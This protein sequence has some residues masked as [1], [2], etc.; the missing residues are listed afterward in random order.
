M[1]YDP[2]LPPRAVEALERRRLLATVPDGF[3]D[4]IFASGF[5]AAT[6][7]AF[8]P[9][10]RIFVTQ[11]TGAV[12]VVKNGAQLGPPFLSV[13]T[14]SNGERGLLG[15]AFDPQFVTN[16][17]VYIYYTVPGTP[18][19]NRVSRFTAVANP[20]GTPGD[21]AVPG[22]EQRIL[23][24]DNLP[25]TATNHNGGAIHFGPDGKLYVAVGDGAN[26]ANSQTLNNRHG[27]VLRLNKDG[28]IPTDNPF[29]NTAIG[30]NRA[31]WA[32]G[33]RNPF[34]FS[35]QSG[36]SRM[37]INDV[38][39]S[40]FEEINDG[41]RG[42]N[43]GWP[44]TEGFFNPSQFPNFTNPIHAYPRGS[45]EGQ[46]FA[47]TGGAFYNPSVTQFPASFAGDYFFSD[48]GTGWIRTLD[49]AAGNTTAH[50]AGSISQPVDLDVG[51]D[52]ALYYLERGAGRIGRIG[53][54]APA[55]AT[56]D[57]EPA[58]AGTIS[59]GIYVEDGFRF[60]NLP[61]GGGSTLEPLVVNGPAQGYAS[62]VLST[63]NW[64]R[65]IL[66]AR[67]DG[68]A[69]SLTSFDYAAGRW[70]E[71]GDFTVS[72]AF[73]GGST[74]SRSAGF[75]TRQLSRLTLN[76]TNLE[77][78]SVNFAGGVNAA[79]GAIDNFIFG[80]GGGGTDVLV[81]MQPASIGPIP[82]GIYQED[83]FSFANLPGSGGST[84]ET[85]Q[86]YGTPQGYASNVLST[87]NWGRRIDITRSGGSPFSVVRFD[88]AAGRWGES[89]DFVV[90]GTFAGGT[91]TRTAS[92]SN[93]QLSTLMLD[94]QNVVK[95]SINFAG[96]ANSAYGALDNFLFRV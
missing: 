20:D 55:S 65:R 63:T 51:P 1:M 40:K 15:L 24:L 7:M 85:L 4:S 10:G 77:S 93:K 67:E 18:A 41:L 13:T 91:Q 75:S 66:I 32:L 72:G 79:Y 35:F 82:S 47:I 61:G 58:G 5:S 83:G 56:V 64:G 96:G 39:S 46:G 26:S 45:G 43:Y 36:S 68:A 2:C 92:F 86:I 16:R 9:G 60:S 74:Q 76:W 62:K 69:F 25:T 30:A 95:L 94:W 29:F 28:T 53:F 37:F 17:F 80:T 14:D 33:L 71:S 6:S 59:S 44:Q 81:N 70:G 49:P 88:Y 21:T 57:F 42:R 73:V 87:T 38:G 12:R 78:I 19:H 27:K 54:N 84:L 8:A 50:F 3:T 23:E 52:G 22:S 11:Q 48:F 34:T 90:T 31:I 89:G